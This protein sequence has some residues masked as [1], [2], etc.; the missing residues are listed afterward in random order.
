MNKEEMRKMFPLIKEW[1]ENPDAEMYC[2]GNH[3]PS[4]NW[5]C[6][7]E[8]YEVRYPKKTIIVNG[9]EVPAPEKKALTRNQ[10]YYTPEINDQD[11]CLNFIWRNDDA[12]NRALSRGLVYLSADDAEKR[13]KAMLIFEE[14]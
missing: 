7:P 3:C 12:D 2:D 14:K 6:D 5:N 4:P 1:V 13:A 10:L 9:V 8:D 11:L